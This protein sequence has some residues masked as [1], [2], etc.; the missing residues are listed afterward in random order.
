MGGEQKDIS[1]VLRAVVIEIRIEI[2]RES[3]AVFD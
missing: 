1:R 2:R 3:L